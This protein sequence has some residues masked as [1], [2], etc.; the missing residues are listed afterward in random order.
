MT[1]RRKAEHGSGVAN[2]FD[3]HG[4]NYRRLIEI[5]RRCDPNNLFRMNQNILPMKMASG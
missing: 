5:K 1:Q 4:A 3:A 2:R